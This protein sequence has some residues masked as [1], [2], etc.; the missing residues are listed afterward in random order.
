MTVAA[1]G[2]LPPEMSA[3]SKRAVR[4]KPDERAILMKMIEEFKRPGAASEFR[5]SG[6]LMELLVSVMRRVASGGGVSSEKRAAKASGANVHAFQQMLADEA[7]AEIDRRLEK[8]EEIQIASLAQALQVSA[9][10]LSHTFR[11]ARDISVMAYVRGRRI[12]F[13]AELLRDSALSVTEIAGKCGFESIHAFSRAFKKATGFS[14][15][16]YARSVRP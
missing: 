15:R 9:S 2:P 12:K 1:L 16:A 5:L 3:L 4:L 6:L 7:E 11:D 10:H 13:A 14:P 8:G